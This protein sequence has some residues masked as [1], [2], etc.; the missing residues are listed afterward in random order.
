MARSFWRNFTTGVRG[1]AKLTMNSAELPPLF[2]PPV[3]RS[4][5]KL[6]RS[7]FRKTIPLAAARI[8]NLKDTHQI[9][10]TLLQS[11]E[12]LQISS[13]KSLRE[14]PSVPRSK[15]F[16][17]RPEIS[18]AEP[19]TWS[20][21]LKRL[22]DAGQLQVVG[23]SLELTYEDWSSNNILDATLPELPDED[24]ETPTGFSQVGHVAHLNLRSQYL[25][26]KHLVG[27]VILDKSPITKTVINKTLDVGTESVFRTFPY[28]VL[29]GADDLDVEVSEAGCH[30]KFNFAKVY[31]NPR[32]SHEHERLV[33]KFKEGEAVCDV[34][35]GVGPFAIPAGKKR[36]FVHA[37]D[38]NPD[39]FEALRWAIKKNKVVDY[40][41][42]SCADGRACIREASQNIRQH[43]HKVTIE[44]S[45]KASRKDNPAERQ[46]AVLKAQADARIIER[47]SSFD[48][49][50]MNL[51]ATAIEF[52]DAFRGLNT[53]QEGEFTP[54]TSRKLPLIHVHLFQTRKDTELEEHQ[55]ICSRISQILGSTIQVSDPDLELHYVRLVSP[56][57]KMYC[58]SFRL[59]REVAFATE[60]PV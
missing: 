14:D 48:H 32:L 27:E 12:L 3:N 17:L 20:A 41:T 21:S 60:G 18:P 42:A 2:L 19:G 52:L 37:N 53:G 31:W 45:I 6:D 43:R 47:P 4:M 46:E 44:P 39:S 9:R 33:Q 7:F 59:P 5:Q 58:A 50:V 36:I 26:F 51:P 30:F 57:K 38:L 34:M 56:K 22:V 8:L 13:L 10:S 11:R 40:V 54:A 29:A 15:C 24:K 1:F 25:P 28:E 49:F 35:A 55:E 16:L 23:Y